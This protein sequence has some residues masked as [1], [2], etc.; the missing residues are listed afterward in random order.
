MNYF[1]AFPL[2]KI[3]MMTMCVNILEQCV[4]QSAGLSEGCHYVKQ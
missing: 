4:L 3:G 2:P 1:C